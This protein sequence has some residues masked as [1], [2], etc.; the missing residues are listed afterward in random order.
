MTILAHNSKARSAG[1]AIFSMLAFAA[2]G[3][4]TSQGPSPAS[5]SSL[6]QQPSV[7]D[8]PAPAVNDTPEPR[9]GITEALAEMNEG[10]D[11][12][13]A[14][15]TITQCRVCHSLDDGK[16]NLTG[17]NLYGVY[18]RKAAALEN[19][20]YSPKL[21]NAEITWD[22]ETLDQFLEN[23]PQYLP[24]NRMAFGGVR[25]ANARAAL[26]CALKALK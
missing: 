25:D 17:P 19:F 12:A 15:T 18:G 1:A 5:D 22:D 6:A 13:L 11:R 10:C 20:A 3:G 9:R 21:R 7:P 4:P 14:K 8:P 2:C 16:P 26:I 24:G 23:P